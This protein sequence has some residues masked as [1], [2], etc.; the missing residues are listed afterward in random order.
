VISY[1]FTS[2]DSQWLFHW[3][4]KY[5]N[6][7]FVQQQDWQSNPSLG[8]GIGTSNGG[9]FVHMAISNFAFCV[10]GDGTK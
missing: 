6:C 3:Q 10:D 5:G 9:A 4:W 2:E 1:L 7:Q 8:G